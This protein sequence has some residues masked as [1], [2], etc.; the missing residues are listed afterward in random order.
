MPDG[1]SNSPP[2]THRTYGSNAKPGLPKSPAKR[3]PVH[4]VHSIGSDKP[5]PVK[6]RYTSAQMERFLG[7]KRLIVE[8]AVGNLFRIS[9]RTS[10]VGEGDGLRYRH[11]FEY[12]RSEWHDDGESSTNELVSI[13]HD[14]NWIAIVEE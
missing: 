3:R 14:A 7:A 13:L 11:S 1:I 9:L 4:T 5:K 2:K 12:R 6:Q 8:S 10:S